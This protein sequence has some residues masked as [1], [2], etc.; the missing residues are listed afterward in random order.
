MNRYVSTAYHEAGH[1]LVALLH[2]FK[3]DSVWL[4]S[5]TVGFTRLDDTVVQQESDLLFDAINY[6]VITQDLALFWKRLTEVFLAGRITESDN[7]NTSLEFN[8][9]SD[10]DIAAIFRLH[11]GEDESIKYLADWHENYILGCIEVHALNAHST[12]KL[13]RFRAYLH[14]LVEILLRSMFVTGEQ[15]EKLLLTNQILANGQPDLF[16]DPV[17]DRIWRDELKRR[18]IPNQLALF[19]C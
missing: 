8:D 15:I 5:E 4:K 14:T 11:P 7:A 2:G 16:S 10:G 12:I 6:D 19:N 9:G 17:D 1:A 13:P 18:H 3:I